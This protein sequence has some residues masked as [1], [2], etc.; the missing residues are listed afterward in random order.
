MLRVFS[1]GLHSEIERSR[2]RFLKTSQDLVERVYGYKEDGSSIGYIEKR[3]ESLWV[4]Y[5][6]TPFDQHG[7][8]YAERFGYALSRKQAMK[9]LREVGA[10]RVQGKT[11]GV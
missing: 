2:L 1:S 6:M 11:E 3:N 7:N 9:W 8:S 5:R 4:L 10:V